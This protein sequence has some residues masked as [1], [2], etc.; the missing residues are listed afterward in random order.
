MLIFQDSAVQ[1]ETG[2][3]SV[4]LTLSWLQGQPPKERQGEGQRLSSQEGRGEYGGA[5]LFPSAGISS[6]QSAVSNVQLLKLGT[7]M[8]TIS[9][10]ERFFKPY[11]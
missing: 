5:G 10:L 9:L 1:S 4:P 11:P 8:Q 7:N 3:S 6:G 2:R